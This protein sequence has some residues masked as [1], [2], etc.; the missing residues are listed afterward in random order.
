MNRIILLLM[1]ISIGLSAQADYIVQASQPI[2]PDQTYPSLYPAG[3]VGYPLHR[4]Y[5]NPYVVQDQQQ[6]VNPY[7]YQQ[8]CYNPYLYQRPYGNIL[9]Y[10]ATNSSILNGDN[11]NGNQ[12]VMK[13]IGQS[14]LYSML[15]GY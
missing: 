3:A 7:I 2:L 14:I 1:L 5:Q 10:Q 6:Y 12:G 4:H 13:N 9:P 8:Q 15:R 11:T